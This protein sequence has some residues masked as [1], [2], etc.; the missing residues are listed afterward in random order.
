MTN[1]AL[2]KRTEVNG[3]GL[4]PAPPQPL[5]PAREVRPLTDEMVDELLAGRGVRGWLRAARVASVLG[6]FSLYLFLDTYDVRADFN[7]RAVTRLRDQAREGGR[8]AQL[9]AWG[10]AQ[11][12]VLFDLFIR[13]LRYL[14][15]R[16][17]EGSARK[18]ARLEK[19]ATWLRESLIELGPTFIKIGQALGTRADLLPLAYV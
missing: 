17:A 10:W 5:K 2:V 8:W 9:K 1:Q 16:G 7:Q 4:Q 15:F 14:I 11:L 18:E 13:A 12:Y 3:N 19:Q 6:L